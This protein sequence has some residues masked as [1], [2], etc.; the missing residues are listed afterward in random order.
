M[1]RDDYF[2]ILEEVTKNLDP[3]IKETKLYEQAIENYLNQ[4]RYS[5]H[6][7]VPESNRIIF[8]EIHYKNNRS[9]T[10]EIFH[11][12]IIITIDNYLLTYFEKREFD[13]SRK[14]TNLF[15]EIEFML[16]EKVTIKA[17]LG[18]YGVMF[19][20]N[21]NLY[22]EISQEYEEYAHISVTL[23]NN[24]YELPFGDVFE[25]CCE[26]TIALFEE[27]YGGHLYPELLKKKR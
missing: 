16:G 20:S 1:D 26:E 6:V 7:S 17:K 8:N 9:I 4:Y 27:N 12:S 15:V 24:F 25:D 3:R 2:Y 10:R 23:F 21:H 11:K 19:S 22:S 13:V 18:P 5:S 14:L